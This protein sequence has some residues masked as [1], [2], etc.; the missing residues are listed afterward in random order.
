MGEQ[1]VDGHAIGDR[2]REAGE[3]LADRAV[4]GQPPL[5]D[6]LGDGDSGEHLAERPDVEPRVG[7]VGLGRLTVGQA[8]RL[9]HE[10]LTV[11]GDEDRS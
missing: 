7:V 2:R 6:E 11:P 8:A 4:E 1:L 9:L 10:R 3:V 5:L